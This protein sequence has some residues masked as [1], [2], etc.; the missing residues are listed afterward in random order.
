[1]VEVYKIAVQI[2]M[3]NGVS[4]VLRTIQ[5]DLMGLNGAI[6]MTAGKFT[7]MQ[8][9]VAGGMVAMAG[10]ATLGAFAE[11]AKAGGKLLDQQQLMLSNGTSQ[12]DLAKEMATAYQMVGIGGSNLVQNLKMVA[13]LRQLLGG[14]N[15]PEALTLAPV[16]MKAGIAAGGIMHSDPEKAAYAIALIEDNLGYNLNSAGKMDPERAGEKANLIDAI[17]S[18]TN[19]RVTPDMILAFAKQARTAGRLLSDQGFIDMAPVIQAMGGYRAGTGLQAFDRAMVG[20]VMTT[21]GTSWLEKLGLL[22]PSHVHKAESG[23]TRLDANSIAGSNIMAQDPQAWVNNILVPALQKAGATDIPSML[24]MILQSGMANTTNGLLAEL[25]GNSTLNAKDVTNISNASK[26]D[27]YTVEMQSLGLAWQNFTGALDSIFETLGLPA[28]Q[29]SVVMLNDIAG[30]LRSFDQWLAAHPGYASA[31]DKI[32]LGLGVALTVL[33]TV[34]LGGALAAMVGTG[35]LIV[36]L[37]AGLTAIAAVMVA[38]H[39]TALATDFSNGITIIENSIQRLLY[40][41]EHPGQLVKDVGSTLLTPTP[42]YTPPT[43]RPRFGQP[44]T[45]QTDAAN[46]SIAAHYKAFQDW[47]AAGA[48]TQATVTNPGAIAVATSAATMQRIDHQMSAPQTGPTQGT[49]RATPPG[50]AANPAR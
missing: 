24:K 22:D 1:M 29:M 36:A 41:L 14:T 47:V 32:L 19:G 27:Q 15:L 28:A 49:G 43:F 18:G 8:T 46:A 4:S 40:D 2:G 7:R 5:R 23:Y 50:S 30:A 26:V 9:A 12:I 10:I 21:R 45:A 33:G 20:G 13:D 31:I 17:I 16:L 34:A 37:A 38:G 6:D 39:W 3:Q 11:I 35:G 48:P 44:T 42:G 25:A